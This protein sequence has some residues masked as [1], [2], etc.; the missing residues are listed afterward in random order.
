MS[1]I[2]KLEKKLGVEFKNQELLKQALT[3][4]SY[5]NENPSFELEHNER[6][7]FLGDAVL[8]LVVTEH[9]YK[10]YKNPEGELTSWR[11]ALVNSESL[12]KIAKQ[13]D[14]N[15]FLLLSRGESK[16]QGKARDA[17][18]A[19]SVEAIIGAIYLD[20]GI[21]EAAK[22]IEKNVLVYL[23]EIL[24]TNAWQDAKS[25]FQ[26]RSQE[27]YAITPHYEVLSETGP[28]H[29]K[30]FIVGVFIGKK[31]IAQGDGSS[32][33]EAQQSAAQNGLKMEGWQK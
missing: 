31:M 4:R 20:R 16:D 6:L 10:E 19:N 30:K 15:G 17:I 9:L 22:F 27:V 29:A 11:A 32:K 25:Y 5:L 26:E 8:E 21:K 3:H 13:I 33:Q 14:L 1:D 24:E 28:D 2:S 23:P 12:A 18:L 7:E